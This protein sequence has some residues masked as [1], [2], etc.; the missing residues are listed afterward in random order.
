MIHSHLQMWRIMLLI[1]VMRVHAEETC[2]LEEADETDREVRMKDLEILEEECNS[3]GQCW[4]IGWKPSDGKVYK[5]GSWSHG[6]WY[7]GTRAEK[8]Y[9]D[10]VADH[11][12]W[13]KHLHDEDFDDCDDCEEDGYLIGQLVHNTLDQKVYKQWRYRLIY[14]EPYAD[15]LARKQAEK[16]QRENEQYAKMNAIV[17][18]PV[19]GQDLEME[20]VA[21]NTLEYGYAYEGTNVTETL[22]AVYDWLH[23]FWYNDHKP[24]AIVVHWEDFSDRLTYGHV[25]IRADYGRLQRFYYINCR[26]DYCQSLYQTLD[27]SWGTVMEHIFKEPKPILENVEYRLH[28]SPT[29]D[30]PVR[31][32]SSSI[33]G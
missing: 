7:M 28:L 25:K 17:G 24:K 23:P 14:V 15:Y 8:E 9:H 18:C 11:L 12:E 26:D 27:R 6:W 5:T 22:E 21:L 1:L 31:L 32:A 19:H 16:E 3:Y 2:I 30:G 33:S 4:K 29:S 13:L 20:K 10:Y